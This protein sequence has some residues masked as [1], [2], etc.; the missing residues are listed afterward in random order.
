MGKFGINNILK[1]LFAKSSR[2]ISAINIGKCTIISP[3]SIFVGLN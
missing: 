3:N 2:N 1:I